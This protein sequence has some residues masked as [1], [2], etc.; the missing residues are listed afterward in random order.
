[1]EWIKTIDPLLYNIFSCIAHVYIPYAKRTKLHNK[2]LRCVFLRNSKESEAYRLYDP[3][4]GKIIMSKDVK[5]KEDCS[6]YWD[7]SF[8][9]T[10]MVNL[11]WEMVIIS[12]FL[13]RK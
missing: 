2:S 10:I 7:T 1:M 12:S 6:Y 5:F 4:F 9:E 8:Q 11:E 13:V 3:V